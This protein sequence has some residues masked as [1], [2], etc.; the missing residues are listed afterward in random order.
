VTEKPESDASSGVLLSAA[1][2]QAL[3]GEAQAQWALNPFALVEAAGR[4]CAGAF[5]HAFSRIYTTEKREGLSIIVFAGKGNNAADALVML[6]A[7]ILERYALSSVCSVFAVQIPETFSGGEKTPLSEA[8]L[9]VQKMGVPV[10]AWKSMAATAAAALAEADIVIDG[11]SGTG[12]TGPLRGAAQEMAEL[13]NAANRDK[14]QPL[15]VSI[16][17]PSGNFDGW[18]PE[19]PL[20]KAHATLAIEPRKLCLYTPKAR[21][22]AGTIIPVEGIFPPA[23]I[24]KYREAELVQWES[25]STKIPP[26]PSTAYKYER[27]LVE[28][29]AGSP[30]AT[31]A[32]LLAAQGAQA[33]GAGL[34]R[35]IVDPSLYPIIAPG[36]S[37][38]MAVPGGASD[39]DTENDRFTPDAV[40]LGPGWGRGEDRMRLLE[41][42]LHLEQQGLP[43]I[44]DADAVVLAK[45][46]VFNGNT[47]LTPHPGE[48]AAYT[49]LA[50][51]EILINP[52]P[53]LRRCAAEKKVHI[54]YKSHVLYAASPD[55]RIGIIDGM[56]P[57]LAT[58]GSGDV[59]AGFCASIAARWRAITDR[60]SLDMYACACAAASLLIQAAKAKDIVG[61]FFDPAELAQAAAAI[62]GA[63]WLPLVR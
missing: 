20:V 63:A 29:R 10:I 57:A 60:N 25:A 36:C 33:A 16:D 19:M 6:K 38:I 1:G 53:A 44:L 52:L 8:M 32:A 42:Y 59:L 62:A 17:L 35:L 41:S 40:L 2:A 14:E 18:Q 43:L 5:A 15:V 54:L 48:F 46:I 24:E 27:G 7:L 47:L 55:G 34:V 61:A 51:D 3:D 28:I 31:G 9:A 21:P 4:S 11:I 50:Q 26:V 13:I 56:N 58:G 23:L 30:G 45:N 39:D 12:I 37:G 22:Y 49:G